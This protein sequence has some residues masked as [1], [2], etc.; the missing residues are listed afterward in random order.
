MLI[1]MLV[2]MVMIVVTV[3]AAEGVLSMNV[4]VVPHL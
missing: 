4:L 2:G 1:A 3:L